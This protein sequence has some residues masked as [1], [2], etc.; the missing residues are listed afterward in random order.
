[1]LDVGDNYLSSN[2]SRFTFCFEVDADFDR[3]EK[4]RQK[5]ER[6]LLRAEK[7]YNMYLSPEI[8]QINEIV[9]LFV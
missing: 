6:Y 5:V 4:V 8:R 2:S 1:M 9:I 3:R 7:I